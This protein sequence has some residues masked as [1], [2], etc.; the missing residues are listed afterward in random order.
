MTSLL[1]PLARW[2]QRQVFK[3]LAKYGMR[4]EDLLIETSDVQNAHKWAPAEEMAM[5]GRRIKRAIDLSMKVSS[6]FRACTT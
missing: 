1:K 3:D 5:R 4:Y 2:Y 6:L